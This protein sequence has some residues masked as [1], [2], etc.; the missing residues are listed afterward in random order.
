MSDKPLK[1]K[2]ADAIG[3]TL[4]LCLGAAAIILVIAMARWLL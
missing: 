4:L 3:I 1:D 2:V